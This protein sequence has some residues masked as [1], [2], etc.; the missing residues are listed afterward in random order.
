MIKRLILIIF[1]LL[2]MPLTFAQQENYNDRT[3]LIINYDS[4]GEII[5]EGQSGF[6]SLTT[7][8]N[9]N[10]LESPRQIVKSLSTDPE[11]YL[12]EEN[13]VFEWGT[14]L[15]PFS[16]N[17][18]SQIETKNNLYPV[19]HIQF[20]IQNL[21][22]KYEKYLDA[23]EII[24][25]T[26]EIVNK[27]SEIVSGE[28]DLYSAVFKISEWVNANI[29]YNL[30]STTADAALQS[31]WVLDSREGVCDEISSLFISLS[32]S[33]GIPARFISG[34]AY[35]NLNYDFENHGWAEV[36]FPGEGWVPYDITF[37]Q[38]GWLDP[39]HI[40]LDKSIDSGEASVRYT[41]RAT[42]TELESSSFEDEKT[43]VSTGEKVDNP[44]NF[45]IEPLFY[46]VQQGSHVP[47]KV[48]MKNPFENKY[49]SNTITITKGPTII[50]N[51]RKQ[52]LLKPGQEGTVYWIMRV[53]SNLSKNL[54]YTAEL[55]AKDLFEKRK[56]SQ[57]KFGDSFDFISEQ[58]ANELVESLLEKEDRKYSEELSISCESEK[59]YYYDFEEINILCDVKN[60]G[61]TLLKNTKICLDTNCKNMDLKIGVKETLTFS[62]V[63][64]K[65]PILITAKVNEIDLLTEIGVKI[66]SE[67]DVKILG[68]S[69]PKQIEY[70]KNF[71]ITFTIT[72]IAKVENLNIK[73]NNKDPSNLKKDSL[74]ESVVMVANSK[75]FLS[76]EIFLKLDYTDEYGNEFFQ[77]RN[78]EITITALPW[79]AKIISIF[80][81][82]F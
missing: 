53:P 44:F 61:N 7:T 41:W 14:F 81:N 28:T 79:Y 54:I 77:K 49:V 52:I 17:V 47:V 13:L 36:Y 68:L 8:L 56:S 60:L 71:N 66:F 6:N 74:S 37:E 75:D 50:E 48:T 38:F 69:Y 43:I 58:E 35:S 45:E 9:L 20:P 78:S 4:H 10:P 76:G 29:E 70:G 25:I 23:G 55:E 62:N 30:S 57:I 27:A 72:S 26:P 42:N 73:L 22:S 11:H 64:K 63:E 34:F 82:L 5:L 16:Y 12:D 33:V 59:E 31:S 32:R 80:Y 19:K 39:T 24:D 65:D 46:E 3:G 67:P 18:N 40:A 1:I 51:N 2:I 21:E 15:N